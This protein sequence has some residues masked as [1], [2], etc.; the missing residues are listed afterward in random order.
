M[1]I[2]LSKNLPRYQ[3]CARGEK[4]PLVLGLIQTWRDAS[5]PQGRFL[6]RD[7]SSGDWYAV[8][9]HEAATI[10]QK[11][12]VRLPVSAKEGR[13]STPTPDLGAAKALIRLRTE[14]AQ[15]ILGNR[16]D[17]GEEPMQRHET[18]LQRRDGSPCIG[19]MSRPRGMMFQD[20]S[21]DEY[22][23]SM[24]K[25]KK[26]RLARNADVIACSSSSQV[27]WSDVGIRAVDESIESLVKLGVEANH[28][29]EIAPDWHYQFPQNGNYAE[30]AAL[31]TSWLF[32]SGAPPSIM[33]LLVIEALRTLSACNGTSFRLKHVSCSPSTLHAVSYFDCTAAGPGGLPVELLVALVD[34]DSSLCVSTDGMTDS[35][36]RLILCAKGFVGNACEPIRRGG[37]DRVLASIRTTLSE[38]LTKAQSKLPEEIILCPECLQTKDASEA[39]A[40][41]CRHDHS[42]DPELIC[43]DSGGPSFPPQLEPCSVNWHRSVVIVAAGLEGFVRMS[44][45]GFVVDQRIGL[46]VT[47]AHFLQDPSSSIFIGVPSTSRA[48]V[49]FYRADVAANGSANVDACVLRIVGFDE[50]ESI[51]RSVQSCSQEL[52]FAS[53]WVLDEKVLFL[54][55]QF[56]V[57]EFAPH[58]EC[59]QGLVSKVFRTPVDGGIREEMVVR[60]SQG[61]V[62]GFSGG[63]CV[64]SR[65]DVVGILSRCDLC[66]DCRWYLVPF[67]ELRILL[68]T[69]REQTQPDTST[70]DCLI[71]KKDASVG[72]GQVEGSAGTSRPRRLFEDLFRKPRGWF[73]IWRRDS[74]PPFFKRVINRGAE[75][76]PRTG[77][78]E[79]QS[80]TSRL[81]WSKSKNL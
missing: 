17:D 71:K 24:G 25:K 39:S 66:N 22:S 23:S 72:Q 14:K 70:E 52:D 40:L 44:V 64:N 45:S 67:S 81:V 27:H 60:G 54:G 73:P 3:A 1:R 42:V 33:E 62:S 4:F 20:E 58:L 47:V 10:V 77:Q 75:A 57:E 26:P 43:A 69:A 48:E 5:D 34:R 9:P 74:A 19:A 31:C 28:E 37:Y 7:E 61:V 38:E 16:S 36:Q 30:K 76:M 41:P 12:F 46:V 6:R 13:P 18:F 11:M 80:K 78:D 56:G 8:A 29:D 35:T 49:K 21:V 53:E 15:P 65:G 32:P 79:V 55:Y 50:D 68:Q 2:L 59:R 51:R 63:P